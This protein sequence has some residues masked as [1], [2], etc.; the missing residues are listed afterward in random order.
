EVIGA[1]EI[2]DFS[3]RENV[4]DRFARRLGTTMAETLGVQLLG[5]TP[6]LK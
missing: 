4:F 1:E 2:V 6:I 3:Q 5:R